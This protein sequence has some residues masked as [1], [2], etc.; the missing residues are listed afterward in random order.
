MKEI[1]PAIL[2]HTKE[3]LIYKLSKIEKHFSTAQ[4]DIMDGKFVE[5][6]TIQAS[7]L[8]DLNYNLDFEIHLMVEN[9][10]SYINDFA[11]AKRIIFHI[12]AVEEPEIPDLIKRIRRE[13]AQVGIALNPETPA[14]RIIPYLEMIHLALVM[15]I[16]P[17]AGGR[18]LL[19]ET[20]GKIKYIRKF[21][22][23]IDV[24]VDGG[25]NE[26]TIQ[27]CIE[28]GANKLVIGSAI[29]DSEDI[30]A[31]IRRLKSKL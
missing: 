8:E 11:D 27:G 15:T 22:R 9:P 29:Y 18:E 4:I 10:G 19:P 26:D 31:A 12:E 5:D 25:I 6:T 1:I 7:D 13:G 24:E 30:D 20:I 23:D 2:S 21:A 28:A 3:N 16:Y 14:E 17:G